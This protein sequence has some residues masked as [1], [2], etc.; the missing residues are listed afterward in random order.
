MLAI[1]A[2]LEEGLRSAELKTHR[3]RQSADAMSWSV[4]GVTVAGRKAKFVAEWRT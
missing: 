2:N 3:K 4:C 1:A